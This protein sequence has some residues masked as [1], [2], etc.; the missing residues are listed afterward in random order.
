MR[1]WGLNFIRLGVMWE[2][3]E[4]AP[5]VFDHEYLGKIDDLINQLGESGIHVLVDSHQDVGSRNLCGEGFPTFYTDEASL[6]HSCDSIGEMV[7]EMLGS[8]KSFKAYGYRTDAK[9]LPLIEDCQKLPFGNYYKTPEA[10][11]LYDHLYDNVNQMQDKFMAYWEIVAA[12]FANNP[13]VI[14]YEPVN[15]PYSS[16]LYSQPWIML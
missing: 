3:V 10:I 9:G 14:G 5:G 7:W 16:S 8:C 2:A 1:R 13:Y 11:S 4:T 15:E 6:N 12:K